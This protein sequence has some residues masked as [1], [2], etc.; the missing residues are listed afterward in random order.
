MR[1][2]NS[3]VAILMLFCCAGLPAANSLDKQTAKKTYLPFVATPGVERRVN[4]PYFAGDVRF[5]ETAVFWFGRVTPS[6]NS[7]DVRVGFNSSELYL[8]LAVFDRRLW[9]QTAPTPADLTNW[10]SAT[11][12]LST[13]SNPN[14]GLDT[15]T[16]RVDTQL[17][18]WEQRAN[19]QAAYRGN[20]STWVPAATPFVTDSN[21]RGDEPN[22]DGD[23]RG[24]TVTVHLPF[25]SLGLPTAPP[26][27]TI[28][29]LAVAL[30]DR[31]DSQGSTLTSQAWPPAVDLGRPP[32][33]GELAFGQPTYTAP[34]A[35]NTQTITIRDKLNG[36]SV[37][38]AD[39]GGGNLCGDGLDFWTQWGE[40][41]YSSTA[42]RDNVNVQ[43]QGDVADWPCYSRAYI[44]F[45]LSSLPRGKVVV[46]A[47]LTLHEFSGSAPSR[48]KPS[49][50]QVSTVA[51]NWD[52][53][54]IRWNNAPT[55]VENISSAWVYPIVDPCDW[56][57]VPINWNVSRA[58][59]AA[60]LAQTPLRL[61]LYS[62][63]SSYDSGKYFVASD[64]GDWNA[65]ARPTLTITLGDRLP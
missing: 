37:I 63:D 32:T 26:Q 65:V 5:S 47:T 39:V 62:A 13:S 29:R 40:T 33:W 36:Q 6:E 28:W 21:W 4:V 43:N 50:I 14:A 42:R 45:P 10:D 22:N 7:A 16:Y 61:A 3:L 54:T 64:A 19:Y 25:A 8:H 30:H 31:D 24:W 23:D 27:G 20:G 56:P 58:V 44:S 51:D 57:C 38:D 48:A 11:F 59:S 18:W 41:N 53:A 9:Y 15:T 55:A 34:Q 35:L 60:Y 49:L 2:I 1:M 46:N 17:S 12:Y 52:D